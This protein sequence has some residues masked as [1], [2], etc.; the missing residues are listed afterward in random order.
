MEDGMVYTPPPIQEMSL[1]CESLNL[2]L[3][4]AITRVSV[5]LYVSGVDVGALGE[6]LLKHI[7]PNQPRPGIP[8]LWPRWPTTLITKLLV[9]TRV[10]F[11]T[12]LFLKWQ[13]F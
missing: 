4:G 13:L 6:G 11:L 9:R 7:F 1:C 8:R 3:S 2:A 5:F 10:F 12:Y